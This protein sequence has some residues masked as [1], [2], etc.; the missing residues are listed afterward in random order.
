MGIPVQEG[1]CSLLGRHS[2]RRCQ[3]CRLGNLQNPPALCLEGSRA[4]VGLEHEQL[5]PLLD[6]EG[7]HKS[8]R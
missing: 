8:R 1:P 5:A 3:G 7:F 6:P 2:A 4:S